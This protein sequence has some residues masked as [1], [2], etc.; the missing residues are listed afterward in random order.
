M[1]PQFR[2]LIALAAAIITF[3]TL[4]VFAKPFYSYD[5][6]HHGCWYND[7]NDHERTDTT[8]TDY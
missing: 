7:K 5:R 3:A 2:F 8:K 6:S 1:R 4:T